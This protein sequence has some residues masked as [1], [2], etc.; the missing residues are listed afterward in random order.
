MSERHPGDHSGPADSAEALL[1]RLTKAVNVNT[2]AAHRMNRGIITEDEFDATSR[3]MLKAAQAAVRFLQASAPSPA[4]EPYRCICGELE[5]NRVHWEPHLSA[6]HPYA[7]ERAAAEG[8]EPLD[9]ERLARALEVV[10]VEKWPKVG[11]IPDVP[12][13]VFGGYAEDIA[14]AYASQT[15]DPA[16]VD[17]MSLVDLGGGWYRFTATA[18]TQDV[19]A[20]GRAA[21]AFAP[22]EVNDPDLSEGWDP[23]AGAR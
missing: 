15:S 14:A 6:Y 21:A 19:A 17:E 4:A 12:I 18:N 11:R 10:F 5:Q 16:L 23:G 20:I 1:R 9:V 3:E 22:R 2:V 8:S 13:T 7:G